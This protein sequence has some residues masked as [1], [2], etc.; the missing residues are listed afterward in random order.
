ML[1]SATTNPIPGASKDDQLDLDNVKL[2]YWH[3]LS[4]LTFDGKAVEGFNADKTEYTVKGNLA[5]DSNKIAYKVKG[6]GANAST[7]V[8]PENNVL[9]I[10]VE[11]ND[12]SVN[13]DSKTVYTIH[14]DNTSTGIGSISANEAK[15]HKVYTLGGV[16]VNGKPAAGLYIVDGKKTVVK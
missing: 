6:K 16:R 11:G 1:A 7:S 15:N 5:D 14:F 12:I 3:A 8:D 13:A 4:E 9:K 10:T 2:I